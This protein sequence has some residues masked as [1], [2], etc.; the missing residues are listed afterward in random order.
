MMILTD[1]TDDVA[2]ASSGVVELSANNARAKPAQLHQL[3]LCEHA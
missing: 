2:Q 1:G 3:S